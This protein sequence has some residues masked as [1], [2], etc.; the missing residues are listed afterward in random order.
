LPS[1]QVAPAEELF[2]RLGSPR[3]PE[4]FEESR[5]ELGP[6]YLEYIFTTSSAVHAVSLQLASVLFTLCRA[7]APSAVVDLGSGFS[8]HVVRRYAQEAD[9]QVRVVS[10]D[11]SPDWLETTRGFLN[12]FGPSADGLVTWEE[13]TLDGDGGFDVVLYDLGTMETRA[14]ELSR[15]LAG[16]KPWALILVDDVHFP[17]YREVVQRFATEGQFAA[18]DLEELTRDELGRFAWA[19]VR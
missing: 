12:R 18:Y 19:L 5:R 16:M 4:S 7:T 13:F 1:V 14:R 9:Q 8:S 15:V 17:S 6:A 10:V 2:Q 11:D 3:F